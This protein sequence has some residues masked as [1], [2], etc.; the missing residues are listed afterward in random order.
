MPLINRKNY[1]KNEPFRDAILLVIICE[2]RKNEPNYFNFFNNLA[3]RLKLEIIPNENNKSSPSH[4]IK[5]AQTFIDENKINDGDYKLWF[6]LDIDL[7][8]KQIH[9]LHKESKNRN[10]QVAL[11]NPCFEVWL[12]YHFQKTLPDSDKFFTCQPWKE[13]VHKTKKGGFNYS[14]DQIKIE[15]AIKNTKLNYS[16]TGY[17]PDIGSTQV[18]NLAEVILNIT[19]KEFDEY[20]QLFL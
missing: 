2:G 18:Y 9:D 14:A 5:N 20:L 16:A 7:W 1:Q 6:V 3:P 13:L 10:W 8:K 15:N 4:L 11:S 19:R 12:Y 17:I